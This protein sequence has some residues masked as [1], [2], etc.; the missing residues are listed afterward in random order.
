MTGR[1]DRE[2]AILLCHR[3]QRVRLEAQWELAARGPASMAALTLTAL[4]SPWRLARLHA[5]WAVGQIGRK[6]EDA[7]ACGK[8]FGRSCH[9]RGRHRSTPACCPFSRSSTPQT[10][11]LRKR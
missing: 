1:S 7:Q 9:S 4:E 6:V 11:S 2:L 8:Y 3:D 5:L 10:H